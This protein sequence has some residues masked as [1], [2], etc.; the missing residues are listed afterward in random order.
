MRKPLDDSSTLR[1]LVFRLKEGIYVTNAE[2][3][4]LDANPRLLEIL[5]VPS[6]EAL[7][8]VRAGD[9][10]VDP[11]RRRAEIEQLERLG[12]VKEF[13]LEIRRADGEVRTVLDTC[14]AVR[15]D[16][17]RLRFHGI[18]V[19]ITRRK[20]LE[21]QLRDLSMRD[22]LTGCLNRHF[23]AELAAQWDSA[24]QSWGVVVVDV[25]HFKSFNDREGHLV[26]DR[27]LRAVAKR[28]QSRLRAGDHV[29]RYGGDEFVVLL[30]DAS[31]ASAAEVAERL[32]EPDAGDSVTI[33]LGWAIRA[34][35]ESL[36]ETLSRADTHLLERRARVRGTSSSA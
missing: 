25:D 29:V 33:S 13:E 17:G 19:D 1:N 31:A 20:R 12:E 11:E 5:G 23:L 32:A 3:E 26:G 10:V 36:A 30:G 6:I 8:G 4:I 24:T 21:T 9:L 28:L 14:F 22:A 7:P 16:E 18:L 2:G 15:D 35:H 27:V 34:E